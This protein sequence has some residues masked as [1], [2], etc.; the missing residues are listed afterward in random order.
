[1]HAILRP[2]LITV[3]LESSRVH[4]AVH[5]LRRFPGGFANSP[6]L[7]GLSCPRLVSQKA[8][9]SLGRFFGLLSL[10]LKNTFP[11]NGDHEC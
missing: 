10:A 2:P 5:Q 1:M 11:R 4:Q 7:A 3:W 9:L 6:G 8:Q